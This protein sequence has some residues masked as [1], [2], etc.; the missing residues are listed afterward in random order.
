MRRFIDAAGKR[1]DIVIGRESWGAN[2]ALFVP[3]DGGR[4]RQSILTAVG[5][6]RAGVELDEYDD[7]ALR[8][9]FDRSTEKE[10]A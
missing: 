9:L 1:W 3:V 7:A 2:V 8:I 5:A 4:V 6:D 10:D